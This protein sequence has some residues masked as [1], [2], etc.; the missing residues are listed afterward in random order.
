VTTILVT[1]KKL[2]GIEETYDHFDGDIMLNINSALM[3]LNQLNVGP[4]EGFSIVTGEETWD[5]YLGELTNIEA[6]KMYIYYAVRLGFDPPSNS[7]LISA[8]ERQVN[9]LTWRLSVQCTP[10]V[11]T[12]EEEV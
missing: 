10:D 12:S 4:E 8:I 2:L 3:T 9:E 11:E 6:V 5:D 1:I 7:H